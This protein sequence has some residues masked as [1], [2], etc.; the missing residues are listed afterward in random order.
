[1]LVSRGSSWSPPLAHSSGGCTGIS[2]AQL[3]G[4]RCHR[5]ACAHSLPGGARVS[6]LAPRTAR[7]RGGRKEGG[8]GRTPISAPPPVRGSAVAAGVGGR[9]EKRKDGSRVGSERNLGAARAAGRGSCSAAL[10]S[11]FWE[12][13][14]SFPGLLPSPSGWR[15]PSRP[16]SR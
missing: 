11:L 3:Q 5:G 10:P 1:M 13:L 7:P 16:D 8:G 4:L 12:T 6:S 2:A 9:G 15:L 14:L